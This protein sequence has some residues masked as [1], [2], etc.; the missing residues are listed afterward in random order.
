MCH[1]VETVENLQPLLNAATVIAIGPGLGQSI[2]ARAMLDAVK[3]VQKPIVADA[4]AL[5]LMAQMPFR[6][7]QSVLTPHPGEAAKLIGVSTG[8][9]Q[10]DRFSAVKSLQVHYGGVCVLKGAG[11]LIID[12]RSEISVCPA[13]NPGMA[14]GGMGDVLTGVIAG[15]LAQGLSLA[16]AARV[17]V[18]LH[19]KAG[20][21]VAQE[22][23]ERGLLATDLLPWLRYYA[24]PDSVSES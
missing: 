6:F 21:K 16:E 10:A 20:D 15:L 12:E 3:H 22:G 2:W 18:Y 11:S 7:A 19:A 4:D 14:C 17:G 23:G 24:N 13:G 5:N 8:E 1:G 9:I